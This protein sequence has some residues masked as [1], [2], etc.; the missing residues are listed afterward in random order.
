LPFQLLLRK[1]Q[2]DEVIHNLLPLLWRHLFP[3][4]VSQY[5]LPLLLEHLKSVPLLLL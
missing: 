1:P 4:A 5:R 3:V 2:F